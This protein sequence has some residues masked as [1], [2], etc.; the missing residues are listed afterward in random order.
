MLLCKTVLAARTHPALNHP[1]VI[2]ID[3]M[4]FVLFHI[5]LIELPCLSHE[6]QPGNIFFVARDD[7]CLLST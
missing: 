1:K 2:L 5:P 4:F 3:R 6:T 7:L